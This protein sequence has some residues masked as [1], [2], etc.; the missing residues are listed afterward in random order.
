MLKPETSLLGGVAMA[1]FVFGTYQLALPNITD[2]RVAP[3]HDGDLASSERAASWITAGV[4]SGVSLIAKD[5]TIF[6]IGGSMVIIMAWWHRH[7]NAVAPEFGKVIP[8][9]ST[10]SEASPVQAVQDV[11]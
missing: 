2:E 4:V 1:T 8:H 10:M 3:A 9:P 7:A 5:P 11:V 6:V